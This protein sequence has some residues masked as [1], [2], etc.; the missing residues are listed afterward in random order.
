VYLSKN[1][2]NTITTSLSQPSSPQTEQ[3]TIIPNP[4]HETTMIGLK[5]SDASQVDISL[6]DN[7]GRVIK[8][9]MRGFKPA[10][11][12]QIPLPKSQ[13]SSKILSKGIYYVVLRTN[14]GTLISKQLLYH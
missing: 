10:G 11:Q 8:E 4:I 5:L 6:F 2:N 12:H 14:K 7:Q 13:L 3:L 9:I 1:L